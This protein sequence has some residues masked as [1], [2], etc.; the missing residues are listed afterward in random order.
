VQEERRRVRRPQNRGRGRGHLLLPRTLQPGLLPRLRRRPPHQRALHRQA[1]RGPRPRLHVGAGPRL[2]LRAPRPH[3][4]RQAR[5][6]VGQ[7]CRP[8]P[9]LLQRSLLRPPGLLVGV[10]RWRPDLEPHRRRQRRGPDHQGEDGGG[11]HGGAHRAEGEPGARLRHP[12]RRLL[13]PLRHAV[14]LLQPVV[15]GERRPG[16]DVPAGLREPHQAGR[17]H[18][19]HGRRR[20]LLQLVPPGHGLQDEPVLRLGHPRG[21]GHA[22]LRRRVRKQG[23][24]AVQRHSRGPHLPPLDSR[25]EI[26]QLQ[27]NS[28]FSGKL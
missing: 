6:Q 25:A 16:A 4:R 22:Q 24:D 5:G 28:D 2:R 27:L 8:A 9:A 1:P 11:A 18:A 21:V 17:G 12:R 20:S 26:I 15:V 7:R 10:S 19:R 3:H 14:P 23:R 13:R